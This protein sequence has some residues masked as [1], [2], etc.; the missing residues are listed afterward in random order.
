MLY[1]TPFNSDSVRNEHSGL[2]VRSGYGPGPGVGWGGGEMGGGGGKRLS[3]IREQGVRTPP[4]GGHGA[5]CS[6]YRHMLFFN[7]VATRRTDL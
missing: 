5:L 6:C 4:P 2:V 3:F 1:T 7:N